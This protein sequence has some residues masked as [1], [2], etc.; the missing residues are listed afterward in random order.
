MDVRSLYEI[1][2]KLGSGGFGSVYKAIRLS[3]QKVVAIKALK[4][5]KTSNKLFSLLNEISILEKISKEGCNPNLACYYNHYYDQR[6]SEMII[7]MEIIDGETLTEFCKKV[8]GD[9]LYRYL[10]LIVKDLIKA[11]VYIH[12]LNVLHNDIKP[13]NIMIDRELTPKLVD[14]GLACTTHTCDNNDRVKTSTKTE[15]CCEGYN[16][17]PAFASPEMYANDIRYPAS[18]IWSLG[19]TLYLCATGKYPFL[20]PYNASNQDIRNTILNNDPAELNTSN[21]LLNEIVNKALIKTPELR[22]TS[23]GIDTLLSNYE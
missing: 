11:I 23:E 10:L 8:H 2:G 22:I 4:V 21:K 9:V 14:F 15:L 17:T 19:V 18:D 12:N 6:R 20:F 16:G 3:D 1:Q 13:D 7:E 5:N